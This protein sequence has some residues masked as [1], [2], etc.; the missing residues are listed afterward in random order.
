MGLIEDLSHGNLDGMKAALADDVTW[1]LP[2]SLPISGTYTGKADIFENLLGKALP[3]VEPDS[4]SIRVQS[5]IAEDEAVAVE[6]ECE[7]NLVGN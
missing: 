2:G 7:R 4:I 3:Y 6:W 1:W 5:A